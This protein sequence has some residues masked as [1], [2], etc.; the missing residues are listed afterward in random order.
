MRTED[1]RN[2]RAIRNRTRR[3]CQLR[4][5]LIM[6]FLTFIL[7]TVFS[8]AFF[9]FRARAQENDMK[10]DG[11]QAYKY[12]KS[13]TVEAGDTLWHYAQEYGD[14]HYY[15]DCNA[16]IQEV[17]N[18]NSLQSDQITTGCHLILPYYSSL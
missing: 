17:K 4:S 15:E 3:R 1:N 6:C 10:N 8:A 9:G 16:Y 14:Q 5:R 11:K 12:Y 13:I 7:V 2:S 18:I